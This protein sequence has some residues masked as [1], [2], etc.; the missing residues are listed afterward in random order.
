MIKAGIAGAAGYTGG[1]LLR[2]LL[3]HEAVDVQF[4]Q[5]K[6]QSG[7]L[8]SEVH[9]DLF[10]YDTLKFSDDFY[11][12]ID[13][14]FLCMGNGESRLF[15]ENSQLNSA[16]K[17]ID[18]SQDFRLKS[19]DNPLSGHFIY[20]LPELCKSDIS[21]AKFIANPGCFATAITLGLLPLV[22]N[23]FSDSV[24]ATGITGSTGAGQSLTES[25]HFSWRNNNIQ[26]YKSLTHQHIAEI[27]A[28]LQINEDEPGP[29]IRFVPWRGDFARG[30]FVSLQLDSDWELDEITELYQSFYKESPFTHINKSPIHL[31]QVV[32]TN[33]CLIQIEKMGRQVVIHVAIDNLLK[34]ASGQAVQNMN[35]MFGLPETSGLQLKATYF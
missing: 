7:K 12:D 25:S 4:V 34:G 5:S 32:N 14:L 1:E 31:K 8:I 19:P 9:S 28:A 18:L 2:L 24:F 22:H 29:D 26:A 21:S 27:N 3:H 33:H 15:M 16:T 17:V 13:I 23:G 6:S 20:G 35:L 30:I 11:E 10:L